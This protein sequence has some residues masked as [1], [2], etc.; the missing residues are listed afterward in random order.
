MK[1]SNSFSVP[2]SLCVAGCL[3]AACTAPATFEEN[4]KLGGDRWMKNNTVSFTLPVTD[5]LGA[6]AIIIGL[7]NNNDYP[8]RNIHF[9]VDV[10][11]P[12]GV[13]ACD[14]VEYEL[15]DAQGKWL[16]KQGNYWVDHRLLYRPVVMFTDTGNYVFGL[17]HGMRADTLHG[18]GAVGLRLELLDIEGG[19]K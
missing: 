5:T 17:R 3:F 10:T 16:G 15:A 4:V 14:T 13:S 6:Y 8:F 2:Y 7:R 1:G 11:S 9:F 12:G 19:Q 18:I